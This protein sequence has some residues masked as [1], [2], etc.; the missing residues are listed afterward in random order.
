MWHQGGNNRH[1]M[2]D[3]ADTYRQTTWAEKRRL[4]TFF[5]KKFAVVCRVYSESR[6]NL[7][8]NTVSYGGVCFIVI[9]FRLGNWTFKMK[10]PSKTQSQKPNPKHKTKTQNFIFSCVSSLKNLL[11]IPFKS[12]KPVQESKFSD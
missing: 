1:G 8:L 11:L 2:C 6:I 7:T 9:Y 5:D 10:Y 3:H 4:S 12:F